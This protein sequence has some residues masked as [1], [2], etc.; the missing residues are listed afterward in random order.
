MGG[1]MNLEDESV[2]S[3]HYAL[4]AIFDDGKCIEKG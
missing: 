4:I 3:N 2:I 1:E